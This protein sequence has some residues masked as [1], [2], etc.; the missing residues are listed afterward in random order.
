MLKTIEKIIEEASLKGIQIIELHIDNES[1]NF[2]KECLGFEGSA[3]YFNLFVNSGKIKIVKNNQN[4]CTGCK[5]LHGNP[6]FPY[7]YKAVCEDCRILDYKHWVE[8]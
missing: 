1:F 8:E 2:M 6:E 7:D 4:K 3:D 5:R